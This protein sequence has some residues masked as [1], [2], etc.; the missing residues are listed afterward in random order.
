MTLPYSTGTHRQCLRPGQPE[1]KHREKRRVVEK[2]VG[3]PLSTVRNH[4]EVISIKYLRDHNHMHCN[5]SATSLMLYEANF[6]EPIDEY[7]RSVIDILRRAGCRRGLLIDFDYT[8]FIDARISDPLAAPSSAAPSSDAPSSAV[9]SFTQEDALVD[10]WSF[11]PSPA[12]RS[13][14]QDVVNIDDF[15]VRTGTAPFMAIHLLMNPTAPHCVG[16]DLESLFYVLIFVVTQIDDFDKPNDQKFRTVTLP[17]PLASWFLLQLE[18]ETLGEIKTVQFHHYLDKRILSHVK[19]I[20]NPLVPALKRIW[21][22]LYPASKTVAD[23]PEDCCDEFINAL[24]CAIL[25]MP[26][27]MAQGAGTMG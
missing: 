11:G 16:Y 22:A 15:G 17:K 2:P 23:P 21:G 10:L 18:L 6:E 14:A 13:P 20:F 27:T 24:E 12:I 7:S 26:E 5:I 8:S 3:S 9:P 25:N 4:I 19:P 1:T